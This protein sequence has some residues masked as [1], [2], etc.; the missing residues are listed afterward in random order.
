[1]ATSIAPYK[2]EVVQ[3]NFVSKEQTEALKPG[4][5][6]AQV[7]DIL[8]TPLLQSVFH[9]DRWDYV[10]T[11][12]RQGVESQARQ[13]TLY[14]KGDVMERVEGDQ[15]PSESE[16]VTL[17]GAQRKARAVLLLEASEDSLKGFAPLPSA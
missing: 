6:R 1:M 3:G 13:L 4:M 16:F 10:F 9:A 5:T 12:K 2:I 17:L 15:M 8:G 11:M 14:F 7:R